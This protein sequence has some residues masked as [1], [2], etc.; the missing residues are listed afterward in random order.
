MAKSSL[1]YPDSLNLTNT[2]RR[3]ELIPSNAR[4]VE[5]TSP[6]P[7]CEVICWR[8]APPHTEPAPA[9]HTA[10]H[11]QRA[12]RAHVRS[13]RSFNPNFTLFQMFE[14]AKLRVHSVKCATT[15]GAGLEQQ[16]AATRV[17][18]DNNS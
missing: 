15:A 10:V 14:T 11:P 7:R 4:E 5:Q 12:G 2:C 9:A 16:C 18:S 13:D 1:S 17:T 8:N 3:R 6:G